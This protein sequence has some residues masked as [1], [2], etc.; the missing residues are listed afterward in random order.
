MHI[1]G[2]SLINFGV[3]SMIFSSGYIFGKKVNNKPVTYA[4]TLR[5]DNSEKDEPKKLFLELETSVEDIEK[6][7]VIQLKVVRKDYI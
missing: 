5:I 2:K 3:A 6:S 4:G 7:N 1:I